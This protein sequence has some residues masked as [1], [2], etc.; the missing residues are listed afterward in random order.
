MQSKQVGN[1]FVIKGMFA[2]M[3]YVANPVRHASSVI[4]PAPAIDFH[5]HDCQDILIE[6]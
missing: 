4:N 2:G 1:G 5:N 3:A 6:V